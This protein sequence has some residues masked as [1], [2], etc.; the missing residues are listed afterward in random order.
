M[1]QTIQ[2]P[3]NAGQGKS[4]MGNHTNKTASQELIDESTGEPVTGTVEGSDV[5]IEWRCD[6]PA[7]PQTH[8]LCKVLAKTGKVYRNEET[9]MLKIEGRKIDSLDKPVKIEGF[10]RSNDLTVRT[11]NDGK[12]KSCEVPKKDLDVLIA[13]PELQRE[14]PQIDHVTNVV[15]YTNDWEI[16]KPGYNDGREGERYFYTGTEVTP[17]RNPTRTHEFLDAMCFKTNADRTNAAALALTVLLRQMFPGDKPFATVT[18]NRSHAGKDTVLDFC[19]GHTGREEV[20]YHRADWAMQNEVT[21]VLK[22]PEVGMVSVGNIR[23]GTGI[24]ETSIL[25]RLLTNSDPLLQSSKMSGT[26]FKRKADFVLACSANQGK[27]STDL[28]N[29]AIPICLEM[30]G[31]IDKRENKLGDVDIRNSYLPEHRAEIEAELCGMIEN[32][33]A[34][35]K[36]LDESVKHPR[37]EW[38]KTIGGILK[39]NGFTEFL[40]NWAMQKSVHDKISEALALLANAAQSEKAQ[41]LRPATIV[42]LATNEGILGDLIPARYKTCQ[43]AAEREIGKLLSAYLEQSVHYEDDGTIK[44]FCIRSAITRANGGKHASPA[45]HYWFEPITEKLVS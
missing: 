18:A 44:S 27:F 2:S 23:V 32:W 16:T 38:A 37:K 33:K 1:T 29:R 4:N 7:G 21:A 12:L 6:E 40:A 11:M 34:A 22:V 26:G 28:M 5:D 30:K 45:K 19:A 8:E 42:K 24:I 39:V 13:T 15:T 10:I 43:N 41:Y 9:G 20:S 14:I 36:P 3:G 35:G 31:D 17:K 25:E